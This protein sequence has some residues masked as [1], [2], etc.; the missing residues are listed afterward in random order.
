MIKNTAGT[1]NAG[2]MFIVL[3]FLIPRMLSPELKIGIPPIIEISAMIA[4]LMTPASSS[5][6]Q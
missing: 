3:K 4:G 2:S 1:R 6:R 5:A